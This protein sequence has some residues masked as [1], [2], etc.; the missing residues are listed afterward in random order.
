MIRRLYNP[1]LF[2]GRTSY[3]NYFEGW[4]F[5]HVSSDLKQVY[6]FIPGISLS[7]NDSHSFIQIINGI[8]GETNYVEY[9]V[10]EFGWDTGKLYIKVGGSEFTESY[11]DLNIDSDKIAVRGKVEYSNMIRYPGTL[12]SPGIMGWYSFVPF[13]ECKHGVISVNHDL[14]GHLSINGNMTDFFRGKGYIEK[15]WGTSF[16]EAWIWIQSNNFSNA[17][18]SFM[19]SVAKIPWLGKFFTGLISFLYLKGKFYLFSTYNNS[20]ISDVKY[21]GDRLELTLNNKNHRLSL[22]AT[23]NLSGEL[24][25]P[26]TGKMS[27]HIKESIDSEVLIRLYDRENGLILEDSGKRA[28]LEIIE[29]IFDYI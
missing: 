11:L 25:A 28:G 24:R 13:M 15:D 19:L 1:G 21:D 9:P 10:G 18:T 3:R 14:T 2:Q 20:S 5:K 27:R 6:S 22:T 23:K 26:V 17:Q 12:F 8:T 7:D 4:Y 29:K 16:P